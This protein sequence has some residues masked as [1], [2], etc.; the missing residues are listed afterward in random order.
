[1]QKVMELGKGLIDKEKGMCTK[2]RV[3]SRITAEYDQC[4]LCMYT[5]THIHIYKIVKSIN[6]LKNSMQFQ[7]PKR[8]VH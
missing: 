5:Y 1:M 8:R 7:F 6:K 2:K 3:I 4:A